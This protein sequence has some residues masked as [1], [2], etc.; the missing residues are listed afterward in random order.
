MMYVKHNHFSY[1]HSF[2]NN[3]ASSHIYLHIYTIVF[4]LL[5]PDPSHIL[6]VQ[7][8]LVHSMHLVD[9]VMLLY[10][11]ITYTCKKMTVLYIF[12]RYVYCRCKSCIYYFFV[13]F[14]FLF[15]FPFVLFVVVAY[16]EQMVML[17]VY[18][19]QQHVYMIN[20]KDH[21]EDSCCRR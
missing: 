20:K 19:D 10:L 18:D 21:F 3:S 1:F 9:V 6:L 7:V 11:H 17:Y 14:Q 2:T 16:V 5:L 4:V 15:V 8:I 12:F 13:F